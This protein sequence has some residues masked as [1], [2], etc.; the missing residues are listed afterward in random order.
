MISTHMMT[1]KIIKNPFPLK[2]KL[3]KTIQN[4]GSQTQ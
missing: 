2:Y 4:D 1:L 3:G